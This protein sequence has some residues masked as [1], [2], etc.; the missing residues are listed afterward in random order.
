M[1]SK[2]GY[3]A[4]QFWQS[5]KKSPGKKEWETVGSIL[6]PSEQKLFKELPVPDQNHS[7]RVL[8]TL[9]TEGETDPDLLKAALLHDI[10]KARH[11]LR[12]VERILAVLIRGALPRLAASWSQKDPIGIQRALVVIQ[13]HPDWGAEMAK[14]AGSS[15]LV[16]WLIRHHELAD[17]TGIMDQGGVE[18]LGKLQKADNIN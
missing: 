3:R 8:E 12:R 10:G 13:Q 5:L 16:V 18:L 4:W 9:Q 17:L 7:L 15:Q 14:S 1:R 11:P 6:T 2:I